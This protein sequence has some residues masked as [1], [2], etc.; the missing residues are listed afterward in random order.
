MT[1]VSTKT[2]CR[3]IAAATLS[4]SLFAS[5]CPADPMDNLSRTS[6]DQAT[7]EVDKELIPENFQWVVRK[8]ADIR[9]E[10]GQL[11]EDPD[12]DLEGFPLEE[13]ADDFP[14]CAPC[15]IKPQKSR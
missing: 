8:K 5:P 1:L 15:S 7:R 14:P 3:M 13:T 10:D 9:K 2:K 12:K 11:I 6:I 4:F